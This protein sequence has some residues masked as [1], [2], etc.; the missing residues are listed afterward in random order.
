MAGYRPRGQLLGAPPRWRIE[1][2]FASGWGVGGLIGL[3]AVVEVLTSLL[4]H[5]TTLSAAEAV[6]DFVAAASVLQLPLVLGVAALVAA[7][8]ARRGRSSY[9][10]ETTEL[11]S[12]AQQAEDALGHAQERLHELRSAV[13]GIAMSHRL[14]QDDNADIPGPTKQRLQ[15]LHDRELGRLERLVAAE[16]ST[17]VDRVR[18]AEVLDPLVDSLRLAGHRVRW[19]GTQSWILG[20]ADDVAGITQVLLENSVRHA[21]GRGVEVDVSVVGDQVEIRVSDRG[22]GVPTS[23]VDSLFDRGTRHPDSPGQG[24]GLHLAHRLALEMDGDLRYE[25]VAQGAVFVLTLPLSLHT[26]LSCARS[27]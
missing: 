3:A 18:L 11:S 16:P 6:L 21:A 26:T 24:L 22:P 23:L 14:L 19:S 8:R 25:S 13:G 17:R 15:R 10:I 5:P 2:S 7:L 12:R 1:R 4:A 9:V 27:A 20:R